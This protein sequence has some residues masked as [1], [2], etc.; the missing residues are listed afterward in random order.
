M[1]FILKK[2]YIVKKLKI[3]YH[4]NPL[5]LP[6]FVLPNV[7]PKNHFGRLLFCSPNLEQFSLLQK[8]TLQNYCLNGRSHTKLMV[9]LLCT[10]TPKEV[11][12][13][14]YGHIQ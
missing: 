3:Q 1:G 2:G 5:I 6:L 14:T 13:L 4:K 12:V 9:W 11:I 10:A 8:H 7:L